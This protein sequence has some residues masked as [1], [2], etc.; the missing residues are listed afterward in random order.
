MST[1]S[2]KLVSLTISSL[3]LDFLASNA[4]SDFVLLKSKTYI[5]V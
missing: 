2:N 4:L 1:T 3:K 5:F